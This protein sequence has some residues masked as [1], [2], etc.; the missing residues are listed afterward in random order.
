M[1]A[2]QLFRALNRMAQRTRMSYKL[3]GLIIDCYRL[4][5][6]PTVNELAQAASAIC[7]MLANVAALIRDKQQ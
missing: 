7:W 6:N 2:K 1:T 3:A 5:P 4:I